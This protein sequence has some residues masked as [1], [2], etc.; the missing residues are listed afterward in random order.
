MSDYD[1]CRSLKASFEANITN[2]LRTLLQQKHLYQSV[3]IPRTDSYNLKQLNG[4]IVPQQ[5]KRVGFAIDAPWRSEPPP[6]PLDWCRLTVPDIKV[7][8]SVCKRVEAYN[9]VSNEDVYKSTNQLRFNI[10]NEIHQA[11]ALVFMCQS[12]KAT[13]DVFLVRRRG[14]KLTLEGRSPI[15]NVTVP[16]AIAKSVRR[17]YSDAV[18]AH[19]SGQTLAGIFLLRTLIEQWARASSGSIKKE[20]DQVMEDYMATL[21]P[22]FRERF[23]S[24]RALYGELSADMHAATGSPEL[25]TKAQ[26][27]IAEHFEARRLFK[28]TLAPAE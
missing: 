8:C 26:G 22:D 20:A 24:L 18:V 5:D 3:E 4:D 16:G 17:F 7:F 21:P 14:V 15:E 23:P 2:G 12:C 19:Q 6:N 25:F 9:P 11:F 1:L 27:E 13:P 28:L 10:K